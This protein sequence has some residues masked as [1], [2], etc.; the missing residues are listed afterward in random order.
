MF[1]ELVNMQFLK[2]GETA[3]SVPQSCW[4]WPTERGWSCMSAARSFASQR[5]ASCSLS[6]VRAATQGWVNGRSSPGTRTVARGSEAMSEC[7]R[8]QWLAERQAAL[9]SDAETKQLASFLVP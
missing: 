9:T 5:P 6:A 7:R 3:N 1:I 8:L 2:L 4:C